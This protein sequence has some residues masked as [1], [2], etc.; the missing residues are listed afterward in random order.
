MNRISLGAAGVLLATSLTACMPSS[1][2]GSDSG[3][4]SGPIKLGA[5]VSQ[6]GAYAVEGKSTKEGYELWA[7][8]V[9]D[10]GGIDVDGTKRK[11]EV[12]YYDD[13]SKPE[14]AIKLTQR[15]ISEDK[16]D[17]LLGP[18]SSGM[19]IATS[20]I[21]AQYK[22]IMFAGGAAASSVFEQDNEYVFS[23]LALTS[24]Y[25]VSGLDALKAAGAKSVGIL[26]SDDAPMTDVKDATVAH[27]KK[28]GLKVTSTQAVPVDATDIKG[29]LGQLEASDP[30]VLVEAGTSVL[31]ILTMRTLRTL[32]WAPE[33]LMIQ[34]P[35]EQ[36]FV[37]ELGVKNTRGVLAPTQW[38]GSAAFEGEDVFGTAKAYRDLYVDTYG[39]EP[40]YLPASASAAAL[41]LQLAIE[42]AGST[43]T[44]DVRKA[45]VDL[46][47]DTFYG[48]INF[49]EPG[50]DSGLTG[51]NIDRKMLTIQLD[52]KGKQV[53]VAPAEA[54]TTK[55]VPFEPWSKR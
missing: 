50:H 26:H 12:V 5:A 49:T 15:L 43:D 42:K 38:V 51:A 2:S 46:E 19:T 54:A 10:A 27:A 39:H 17:F 33:V 3:D 6:S 1:D 37:E 4:D 41:A 30:D 13:Q 28:I 35:T 34:A 32:G 45:L 11:V 25:T 31:G 24:E 20:A 29:A 53:V 8:A 23:P 7:K 48:P 22:K 40:S 36:Q 18:Y 52:A 16:V 44:E 55:V 21:A 14:T 9:N 47:V